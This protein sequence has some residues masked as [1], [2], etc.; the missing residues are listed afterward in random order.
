MKPIRKSSV[1]LVARGLIL[2]L[3]VCGIDN[4]LAQQQAKERSSAKTES[5]EE[6]EKRI[7]ARLDEL[8]RQI[9]HLKVKAASE[10]T[11]AQKEL[12]IQLKELD[13][14]QQ[15]ATRQIKQLRTASADAWQ[16]ARP[17]LE[18]AMD[19]LEKAYEKAAS[20]FR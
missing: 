10:G 9:D 18:A 7:Q 17:K 2:V 11:R 3:S 1:S 6:Y 15:A 5:K 16:K 14:Q 8:D 19:E 12:N 13:K 20:H 4:A